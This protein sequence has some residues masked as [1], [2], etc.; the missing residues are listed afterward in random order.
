MYA[1]TEDPWDNA[2]FLTVCANSYVTPDTAS[3]YISISHPNG[4]AASLD[5]EL[6]GADIV[7][8]LATDGSSE[9]AAEGDCTGM[10]LNG[11]SR[12]RVLL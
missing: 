10:L 9:V 11:K 1:V 7:V 8:L 5:E 12:A 2:H 3:D 4:V 6:T